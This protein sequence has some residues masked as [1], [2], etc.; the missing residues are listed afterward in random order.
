MGINRLNKKST[1]FKHYEIHGAN[2]SPRQPIAHT[3]KLQPGIY[4]IG[5]DN[6]GHL[7]FVP[8]T[9]M[10]DSLVK[11][12][13]PVIVKILNE[14]KEFRKAKTRAKF[15]RYGIIYKRGILLYGRPGT[16]KTCLLTQVMDEIIQDGGIVIF[17]PNPKQ[18]HY[19][20]NQMR[21]IQP[22]ME[23]LVIFEE[24]EGMCNNSDFK[25]LLDGELQLE[26]IIYIATTNYIERV[27]LAFRKRK[28]RFATVIEVVA[29][30]AD[31]RRA[32][33]KAKLDKEDQDNIGEW[34]KLT[35][36]LVIDEIK[37]LIISVCC[38]N[39]P[40]QAASDALHGKAT[41]VSDDE[42]EGD[43]NEGNEDRKDEEQGKLLASLA[44]PDRA[45]FKAPKFEL[46]DAIQEA[47]LAIPIK[48]SS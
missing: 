32:Y 4:T 37:D 22:D 34:V 40:L 21:E 48:I 45:S 15:E 17:N 35:D 19:A 13:D 7:Y 43:E 5:A 28:G 31:T 38:F 30:G 20:I 23:V 44:A 29:P 41:T 16:G 42:E 10:T 2:L 6:N 36:G 18:L 33:L 1:G 8:Q 25:S 39:E 46:S 27:P 14:I 47:L 26:N 12:P 9:T 11:L 3:K 24:F